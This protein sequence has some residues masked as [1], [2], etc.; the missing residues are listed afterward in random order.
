MSLYSDACSL[1]DLADIS[2]MFV[3]NYHPALS[4]AHLKNSST[5]PGISLYSFVF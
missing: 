3:L 2:I 1:P 5:Y 4:K